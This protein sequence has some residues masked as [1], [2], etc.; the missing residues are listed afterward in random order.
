MQNHDE[1]RTESRSRLE[2][3]V[4]AL[5]KMQARVNELEQE[6]HEPLAIIG[7]SCRFPGGA[8]NPEAFWQLL[9][10]AE[11]AIRPVPPER[12]DIDAYYNP[13][14]DKPGKISTRYGGFLDQVDQ[15]DPSVFNI[16]PRET[17]YLD[18]QQR[19]LLEVS[20]EA[21]ERAGLDPTTLTGTST[22]IFV[23][24]S[25]T[26]FVQLLMQRN[27]AEMS[28]YMGSG[29]AHSV[30]AGRISF[31][32]GLQGPCVAIDTA[33]SS[34]LVSVHLAC[35]SLRCRECDL[36]LA[37]GVNLLLTPTVSINQSLA[38]ML[39]PDGRCKA[40]DASADGFIRSEGCGVIVIKRL[41]EA[42]QDG[43]NILAVIQGTAS[44]HDGRTSG[45]TVPSGPSQE[46]VIRKALKDARLAPK[47]ISYVE[48]HGTGTSLGDPIE[49]GALRAVFMPDRDP[50]QP[51]FVGSVKTNIGHAEAAAGIA[52]VIK[53]VLALQHGELPAHLHFNT[54]NPL[55]D[56]DGFPVMIPT[57]KTPWTVAK[58]RRIAGVSSF[59]FGGTNAH[60]IIA[61]TP[62]TIPGQI[63]ETVSERPI[64]VL[65]LSAKSEDALRALVSRYRNF[66]DTSDGQRFANACYSANTGRAR[67]ACRM[68]ITA[69]SSVEMGDKLGGWLKGQM[70]QSVTKRWAQ[71]DEAAPVAFL[72]TG[73]GSQYA[74]MGRELYDTQP[75]FREIINQC[76]DLLCETLEIPLRDVLYPVRPSGEAVIHQTAYTQP[77]LFALEY[78][79]AKVWQSWGIQPAVVMG[80]SVGEYVAACLSGVFSLEDG[81]RLIAARGRLMQALPAGGAMLAV[82]ASETLAADAI[83]PYQNVVSLAAVNGPSNV[84]ISG[85]VEVLEFLHAALKQSGVSCTPLSVSHAF[86][87]P[88]MHPMLAEFAEVLR[89]V[90]FHPPFLDMVSNVT[91]ELII[92][93]SD[94]EA[95]VM[96]ATPEYWL[97]HVIQPVRFAKGIETLCDNKYALFLEIGPKPVLSG[98]GRQI[99]E[100]RRQTHDETQ[101]AHWLPTLRQGGSDWQ[102]MMTTLAELY[103]LGKE[104]DWRGVERPCVRSKVTL[105]TYPFQRRRYWPETPSEQAVAVPRQPKND[106]QHLLYDVIWRPLPGRIAED[107]P[108]EIGIEPGRWMIYADGQGVGQALAQRLEALNQTCHLLPFPSE[109]TED[110][111]RA[112][113][114]AFTALQGNLPLHGVIHLWSTDLPSTEALTLEHI[115]E[116]QQKS[117][118][119]VLRLLQHLIPFAQAIP[120]KIWLVTRGAVPVDETSVEIAQAPL[121]GLAKVLPLEYP[122]LFGGIIDL[123]PI[124][125]QTDAEFEAAA[126][127][128]RMTDTTPDNQFALRGQRWFVPRLKLGASPETNP[129]SCQADASY[130]ISGGCG[131]LGLKTAQWLAARGARHLILTGRRGA[132]SQEA[133]ETIAALKQQGV[134]AHVV[135]VD[136]AD[137]EGMKRVFQ[138]L[139][140]T[141]PPLKGIVHAAG[142]AGID[143]LDNMTLEAFRAVCRPKIQGAWILH[144]LSEGMPLD[145]FVCFSSISSVWGSKAHGHYAAANSFLDALCAYRA[146]QGLPGLSVNWGPWPDGGMVTEAAQ[147]VFSDW[148]LKPLNPGQAFDIMGKLLTSGAAQK[149]VANID[150]PR[151]KSLFERSGLESFLEQVVG[152]KEKQREIEKP[153]PEP[154]KGASEILRQLAVCLPEER[155]ALLTGFIQREVSRILGLDKSERPDA[156]QGFT[157]MG[158]DSLMSLEL[159]NCLA[160][161]LQCDLPV[162]LMFDYPTIYHLSDYLVKK[163]GET[164][165]F[166]HQLEPPDEIPSTP[167]SSKNTPE[168]E[169]HDLESS[170]AREVEELEQLLAEE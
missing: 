143:T 111:D 118:E 14:P 26:D 160:Q 94:A 149:T 40:F 146:A 88:L 53:V 102:Q 1:A 145:L 71:Y 52:G 142:I 72:F 15:F 17:V 124:T 57:S 24:I 138:E 161:A 148:G 13:D 164:A 100:A 56:W 144:Q 140:E 116:A 109:N 117:T 139:A 137:E 4:Y 86:H 44:N 67:F 115:A 70:P 51:L 129:I 49:M 105:P 169:T 125:S 110:A 35:Q 85:K 62:Q 134:T 27:P 58:G 122:S 33:C 9:S 31:F 6:K 61:E 106:E 30:A 5:Q 120:P 79:L 64:H 132:A 50:A 95:A 123:A 63:P 74:G 43:D 59:G 112:L 47:D 157:D 93:D 29:N 77:A 167:P 159:K 114:P 141:M 68:A 16:S 163:L 34:S 126:L 66:L 25:G 48:A 101:E 130:L 90:K 133:Q 150:W 151:F 107:L 11:D 81:I 131:A 37:A 7:L 162:S 119:S 60:V 82:R 55:I 121:W 128:Q 84:V 87:S 92:A 65:T 12:W 2:R 98:M 69:A 97:R 10:H 158:M 8:D 39:P 99:V 22:G 54:P 23:G 135:Q 147:K 20:W 73:Q 46:T 153:E 36:A 108:L 21:L 113:T 42:Q 3:A 91:G 127:L 45:L 155:R 152:S 80:H 41:S 38:H 89:N 19:L 18:P 76:H 136:V 96:L 75:V 78:A 154:T 103:T 32:L 168:E 83:R 156:R 170:I 104:I 165:D 28:S 166:Q